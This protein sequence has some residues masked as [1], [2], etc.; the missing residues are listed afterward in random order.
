MS[1]QA[2]RGLPGGRTGQAGQ[3][4][5]QPRGQAR[6][7]DRAIWTILGRC[8][9]VDFLDF[10]ILLFLRIEMGPGGFGKASYKLYASF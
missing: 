5:G 1:G 10:G 2:R 4:T 7:Q 6:G 9:F 8:F 3:S